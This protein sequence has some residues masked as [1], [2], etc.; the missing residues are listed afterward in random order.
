MNAHTSFHT[1]TL[2]LNVLHERNTLSKESRF[3]LS[4]FCFIQIDESHDSREKKV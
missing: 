3:F 2:F 4:G 1:S